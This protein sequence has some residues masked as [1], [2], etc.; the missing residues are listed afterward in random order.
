MDDKMKD[1]L[2]DMYRRVTCRYDNLFKTSFP[3]SMGL[4]QTP[5]DGKKHPYCHFY[6]IFY[7]PLL[8]SATV[9]KFMVS[10]RALKWS[11]RPRP[12]PSFAPLM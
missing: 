11:S 1:D 9:R 2:A 7:P 4:R 3:Y 10:G 5:T 8:R 6:M 12:T